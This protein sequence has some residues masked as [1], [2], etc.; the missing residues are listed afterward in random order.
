VKITGAVSNF[1]N[2]Y[3][4]RYCKIKDYERNILVIKSK[5]GFIEGKGKQAKIG[6]SKQEPSKQNEPN[7]SK[8][9][10]TQVKN[11]ANKAR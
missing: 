11:T 6:Q 4:T 7:H 5:N 10:Q 2:S 8:T 3:G 9:N 1:V